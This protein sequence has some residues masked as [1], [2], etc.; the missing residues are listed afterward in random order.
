VTPTETATATPTRTPTETATATPTET[1]TPTRTPTETATPTRTPT[2]T[3]TPTATA[4]PTPTPTPTETATPA[5]PE[6]P[7]DGSAIVDR[8]EAALREAGSFT[9]V[10]ST[11][12]TDSTGSE[13]DDSRARVDPDAGT[14]FRT[15]SPEESVT[16][17]VYADGSTAYEQ[18]V[19]E[20]FDDPRY[21]VTE[22]SR[23]LADRL[24]TLNVGVLIDGID[25]RRAGTVT[26][27]GRT[28]VQYTA[29]GPGAVTDP[30]AFSG[31]R[32]EISAFSSTLLID[33]ETG[34]IRELRT[35]RTTDYL[36]AGEPV[37]IETSVR[38]IGIGSTTVERPKW[39][40]A[41]KAG[42][43]PAA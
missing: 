11:T 17:N 2:E 27:D 16:R 4:T 39:A 33:A 14:V 22:L 38:Y 6:P 31:E 42:G 13:T 26:R 5:G 15:S 24:T 10:Q 40:E 25:Y 43:T 1:V 35:S 18:T 21:E 37:T 23:P 20:A 32:E 12:L 7:L 41:L 9:L 34:T 29:E 19:Q 36:A 8:H 3:V 30:T 28:L